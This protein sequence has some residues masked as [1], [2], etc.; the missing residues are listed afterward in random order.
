MQNKK[1]ILPQSLC[2]PSTCCSPVLSVQTELICIIAAFAFFGQRRPRVVWRTG[3]EK[4]ERPPAAW[5]FEG[6]A[7]LRHRRGVISSCWSAKSTS[8]TVPSPAPPLTMSPPA[9]FNLNHIHINISILKC[10]LSLQENVN[11]LCSSFAAETN[12]NEWKRRRKLF[13]WH[14]R[15]VQKLNHQSSC[16]HWKQWERCLNR[17]WWKHRKC[18]LKHQ[19]L[20]CQLLP[21]PSRETWKL[22]KCRRKWRKLKNDITLRIQTRMWE[23]VSL[24][25]EKISWKTQKN[26]EKKSVNKGKM[27]QYL[28]MRYKWVG[29]YSSGAEPASCYGKVTG[30]NPFSACQSVFGQDTEPQ[31]APDVLVRTLHGCHRH[32]CVNYCK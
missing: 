32:Q 16:N 29:G 1:V 12:Q 5:H 2:A 10:H 13:K 28:N 14:S 18:C 19:N 15:T 8:K 21:S 11:I 27:L 6:L 30:S 3:A 23:R 20:R 25:G 26:E 9:P 7:H 24:R 22:L 17:K 31:T 4:L